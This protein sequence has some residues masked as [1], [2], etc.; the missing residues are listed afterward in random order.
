MYE[1]ENLEQIENWLKTGLSQSPERFSE[2]FYFDK[3]DNQF[4]SL[5]ITDYF[6][7]EDGFEIDKKTSTNYSEGTLKLLADRMQRIENDDSSILAVRRFGELAEEE[8]LSKMDSFLNLN[9]VDIESAS[10]WEIEESGD[11]TID[12]R[13]EKTK[14]WWQFWK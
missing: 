7:F 8:L 2:M 4:F 10:V 11:V 6:I 12:L 14:Y 1:N 9:A 5:L 13:D 3:R